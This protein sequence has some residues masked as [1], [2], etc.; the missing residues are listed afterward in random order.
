[1]T[2][3]RKIE[4]TFVSN[5]PNNPSVVKKTT[6]VEPAIKTEPPQ[7][8]FE[9]K[10]TI[11]RTY[12]II[13]YILSVIE[14]VLVFRFALK[15]L[16]SNPFSGFVSLIYAISDPLALPFQGIVRNTI[17]NTSVFEWSSIIAMAVYLAVASGI[18]YL[19]QIIKP[20]TPEEVN[21]TVDN[22]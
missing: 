11:F 19:F 15:A 13:W 14:T 6:T 17:S 1:M 2:I 10:K 16:G 21:E 4:E 8:V 3:E 20:V 22:P 5:K 18:V 12:Q 9:T 7:K